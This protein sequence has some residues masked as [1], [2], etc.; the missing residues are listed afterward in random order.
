MD[1]TA[2]AAGIGSFHIAVGSSLK[3][4]KVEK[5][6]KLQHVICSTVLCIKIGIAYF[7]PYGIL[8]T[9][10]KPTVSNL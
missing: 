9:L 10:P 1:R 4:W 8:I 2:T 6:V 7:A 5:V 3:L